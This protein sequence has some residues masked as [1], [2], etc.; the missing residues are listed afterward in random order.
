MDIELFFISILFI[1]VGIFIMKKYK[2]YKYETDDMLFAT[3]L[4]VFLGGLIF[5][6]VGV[7]GLITQIIKLF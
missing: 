7:F 2:F 1:L 4:K 6:L 5:G 3:S